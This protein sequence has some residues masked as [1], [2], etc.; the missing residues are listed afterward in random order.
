[1]RNATPRRD[2]TI[3]SRRPKLA[4]EM[5]VRPA[6]EATNK[7]R[8]RRLATAAANSNAKQTQFALT[9]SSG[10][11]PFKRRA[12]R[13]TSAESPAGPA[14]PLPP[15]PLLGEWRGRQIMSP[16]G[17]SGNAHRVRAESRLSLRDGRRRVCVGGAR[18]CQSI[19]SLSYLARRRAANQVVGERTI[20]ARSAAAG[21]PARG[22][23]AAAAHAQT[24]T[25]S[26]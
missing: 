5:I 1:M 3:A 25:L 6:P 19:S 2:T 4:A 9:V 13:E 8:G 20:G 21:R 22:Q 16:A 24:Q 12:N 26:N 11:R 10:R 7:S 15:Q 17:R 14:A 18:A 23:L